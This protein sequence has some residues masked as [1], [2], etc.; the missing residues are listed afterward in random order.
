MAQES[1]EILGRR[2][3]SHKVWYWVWDYLR[4][5]ESKRPGKN[6]VTQGLN[7]RIRQLAQSVARDKHSTKGSFL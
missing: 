5:T 1:L 6:Q 7:E 2:Q 4:K 3:A